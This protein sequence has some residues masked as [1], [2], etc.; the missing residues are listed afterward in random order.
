MIWGGA[1]HVVTDVRLFVFAFSRFFAR[2]FSVL[3]A[4]SQERDPC[5]GVGRDRMD[6]PFAAAHVPSQ[7]KSGRK[8]LRPFSQKLHIPEPSSAVRSHYH[9]VAA[10]TC[11]D[12]SPFPVL[13]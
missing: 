2:C 12:P 9:G 7:N 5:G 11:A 4:F 10:G 13:R 8:E 3:R 6:G 1:A